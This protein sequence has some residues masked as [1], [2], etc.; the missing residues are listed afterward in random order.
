AR[1]VGDKWNMAWALSALGMLRSS[2]STKY[3]TGIEQL[4]E[5]LSLFR[6][7]GDGLGISHALLRLAL[8]HLRPGKAERAIILAEEA[9]ALARAAEDLS[10]EASSL[11]ILS[12][13]EWHCGHALTRVI[14]LAE[15]GLPLLRRIQDYFF[16]AATLSWLGILSIHAQDEAK[17]R[18]Y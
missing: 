5:A 1:S 7:L 13:A 6:E 2:L 9:L 15:Q 10:A 12:K 3:G 11:D 14:D 4:E 18:L 16:L 8:L 17:A